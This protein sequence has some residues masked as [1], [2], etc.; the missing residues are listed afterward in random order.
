MTDL[1]QVADREAAVKALTGGR[2]TDAAVEV[3]G[4]AAAVEEGLHH[5]APMG[6]YV[7]IGT[8]TLSAQATLSPGYI[9]RKSL[10]VTAWPGTCRNTSTNPWCSWTSSSTSIPS[11]TSPP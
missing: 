4:V 1:P 5:L 7:I 10:T 6:R 8:N 3:T 11:T 9:T 2:G